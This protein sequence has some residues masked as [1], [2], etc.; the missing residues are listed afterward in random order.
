MLD[1]WLPIRAPC[2]AVQER[3]AALP[4]L[5]LVFLFASAFVCGHMIFTLFLFLCQTGAPFHQSLPE[6]P[7]G[8]RFLRSGP[9]EFAALVDKRPKRLSEGGGL[10]VTVQGSMGGP[11]EH[12]KQ[13]RGTKGNN[14]CD[15]C[16]GTALSRH[17]R[18]GDDPAP[19]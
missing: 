8:R 12:S 17:Q 6:S 7:T 15:P 9:S 10:L 3:P 13:Q 14:A 18:L 19:C 4:L 1:V 16:A 2:L 5:F 11:R